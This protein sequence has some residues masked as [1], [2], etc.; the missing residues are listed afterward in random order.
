MT[1]YT[2]KKKRMFETERLILRKIIKEDFEE[3]HRLFRDPEVMQY[4]A[5]IKTEKDTTDWISIVQKSYR[6]KGYGPWAV[7][8]KNTS[9]LIGYCG[10]YLQQGVEGKDEV[11][12]LYGFQKSYWNKGYATE[13]AKAAFIYVRDTYNISRFISLV[14]YGNIASEE[15]AKKVGMKVEKNTKKWGRTYKLYTIDKQIKV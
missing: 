5:D 4:V 2:C 12:L 1:G 8:L 3:L 15:V 6:E 9:K 14:E 10:T 7:I 13:A 11:E